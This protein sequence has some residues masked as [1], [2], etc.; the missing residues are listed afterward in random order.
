[1]LL[2]PKYTGSSLQFF[3]RH[4]PLEGFEAILAKERLAFED[5]ER[6]APMTGAFLR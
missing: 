6:H 2:R 4:T 3:L 5:H 1:V